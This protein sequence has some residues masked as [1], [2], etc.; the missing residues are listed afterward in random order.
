M[1]GNSAFKFCTVIFLMTSCALWGVSGP[2]GRSIE[3]ATSGLGIVSLAEGDREIRVVLRNT[4]RQTIAAYAVAIGER[5]VPRDSFPDGVASPLLGPNATATVIVP[6]PSSRHSVQTRSSA[7]LRIAAAIYENGQTEGENKILDFLQK[8][9]STAK[10][11]LKQYARWLDQVGN[12]DAPDRQARVR[13]AFDGLPLA[14]PYSPPPAKAAP[15]SGEYERQ[16]LNARLQRLQVA[17]LNKSATEIQDVLLRE[18][19][20]VA[21]EIRTGT[22]P[23]GI[24]EASAKPQLVEIDISGAALLGSDTARLTVIEVSDYQ[25]PFCRRHFNQTFPLIDDKYISTGKMGYVFLDMPSERSHPLALAAAEATHCAGE[26]GQ[27]WQMHGRLLALP[28]LTDYRDILRSSSVLKLS[29]DAFETCLSSGKYS[30]RVRGR[31]DEMRAA[32]ASGTPY[33]FFG[34]RDPNCHLVLVHRVLE[35]AQPFSAFETVIDELLRSE[36]SPG[37]RNPDNLEANR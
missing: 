23:V 26:E 33:F 7:P 17:L 27:Y 1:V 3:N 22:A 11:A 13:R 30:A 37:K 35:G 10:N 16:V 5:T 34:F 20:A 6:V 25:C 9:R 31:G 2:I 4:S 19:T 32:G 14:T 18:K 8:R 21:Q 24:V 15:D 12:L 36:A 28:A 29:H